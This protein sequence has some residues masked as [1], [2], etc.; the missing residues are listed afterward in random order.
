MNA[1]DAMPSR[2]LYLLTPDED[3]PGR[4]RER[5][6]PLLGE[7]V[8]MLQLRNKR[9]GTNL[10]RRLARALLP[11]CHTHGVPLI[12]NDDWRLAAE[13]GAAGAH[14]GADDGALDQAR[15]V[16]GK[17]AILGASCYDD[18]AR[19]ECARSLGAS[20]LAFGAFFRSGT[21]PMAQQAPLSLLR[22]AAV[23]RLPMVA[24]GGITPDNGRL[25][26]DAGADFI[27]V[28]GGVFGAADPAGA[29]RT[30]RDLFRREPP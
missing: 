23:L 27:A 25:V 5:V 1:S 9:A 2:G 6:E 26:I 15:K 18:A 19:A 3:D 11:A 14:L 24:I 10:L 13:L 29:V 4:L 22:Q 7:G 21:K 8:A 17:H 12:I 20:Y 16:L 30:F 28:L